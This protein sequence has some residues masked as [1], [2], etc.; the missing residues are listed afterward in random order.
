MAS[1]TVKN[2][3]RVL[4]RLSHR[5]IEMVVR[6]LLQ[7]IYRSPGEQLPPIQDLLLLDSASAL[8]YKIRTRKRRT[9]PGGNR[10][11]RGDIRSVGLYKVV[12]IIG[13]AKEA[14]KEMVEVDNKSLLIKSETVVETFI[15]RIKEVNPILNCV[16]DERFE[17]ALKDAREVDSLLEKGTKTE[18]ELERDTPYLGVPFTTKDCIAVKDRPA[19]NGEIEV[20]IPVMSPKAHS[21]F[22]VLDVTGMCHTSGL[23]CRRN[24]KAHEDGSAIAAMK[25][26]G[27][28][29]LALTNVSEACMWWESNNLVHGRSNNPYNTHRIVGGSSGG[30]GCIHAAAASP[31]GIGSDIGG[32][33]RMPAFFN[34]I[35]GHKPSRG[36]VSNF[37]QYPIP[38]GEQDT[39]LGIGPMCRFA[40]DLAPTLRIISG[41]NAELLKLDEKVDIKKLKY[42][43]MEDDGGSHMVS[44][45]Q[46]DIKESL[47]RVV[48]YLDKAHGIKAQKGS[49][50]VYWELCKWVLCMSNHT[51]IGLA[52]AV[53]EDMGVQHGSEKHTHF[54]GLCKELSQEIKDMLGTDGVFLYPTHPTTAPYHNEPLVKP[55]NFSYTGIVNILGLPATHCPLGL[56]T[57]GLPIGIQVIGALNQDRH[58]LA[59]AVELEKAFG[60]WV[61]PSTIL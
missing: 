4:M 40:T 20:R 45:V 48:A 34:G 31:I 33:I 19:E 52:T 17:A 51:F 8:A 9:L 18:K 47:R 23:Y 6:C 42:Y 46:K 53:L 41:K 27:A 37:G 36:I 1:T 2:V 13:I 3:S 16:V 43:Y 57:D 35:F 7:L 11:L 44:P 59:V 22:Y 24:I 12:V 56:G 5:F 29:P 38:V 10:N 54:V 21:K 58:T 32:S 50:N 55:F 15:A 60:G 30:E 39:Y 14:K 26:A 49:L 28:I 61:S 25:R